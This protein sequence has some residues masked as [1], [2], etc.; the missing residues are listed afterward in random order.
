MRA[1]IATF[2]TAGDVYP[3]IPIGR[4][5]KAR[6]AEVIFA[7]SAEFEEDAA[8]EG[9]TFVPLFSRAESEAVFA[10]PDFWHPIKC[11]PLAARWGVQFLRRQFEVL[12]SLAAQPGAVLVANPAVLSA[13]LLHEQKNIPM[14][15]VIL[16]PWIL[17]SLTRPPVLPGGV[18][19]PRRAPKWMWKLYFRGLNAAGDWLLGRELGRLRR[20][21]NLPRMRKVFDWWF[22]PQLIIALFPDWFGFPQADWPVQTRLLSFPEYDGSD[23]PLDAQMEAFLAAGDPPVVITFGTGIR[24]ASD[25]FR[26]ATEACLKLG[27]RVILLANHPGQLPAELLGER[28]AAAKFAPFS[29]LF[30]RCA[31][32]I[33]HGGIGTTAKALHAGI[34]Q[35]ITPICFDQLDNA[36]RVKELKRGE[37]IAPKKAT[38]AR[39]ERK[40]AELLKLKIKPVA[41]EGQT[42][43]PEKAAA[44]L[45]I[46]LGESA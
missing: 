41:R 4:E 44:D 28:V 26:N 10:N 27:R 33:H 1:L 45:I 24:H 14:A 22:S 39:L 9:I 17:R 37:W 8:A 13:R 32:V 38:Q 15:T 29:K 6:G 25:L 43:G 18:T 16:Q 35:L 30:P 3:F 46:A 5:L 34:A 7:S 31:G 36:I 20:D 2:G 21:L 19:L 23:L 40:I 42:F 12:S 11:G